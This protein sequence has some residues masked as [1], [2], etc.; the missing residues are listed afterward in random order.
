MDNHVLVLFLFAVALGAY[1]QTVSGFAM[2][3][4]VMGLV[5]GLHLLP[6][7]FTAVVISLVSL[8]NLSL[9]L[10]RQHQ[11]VRWTI[12]A[13]VCL[14]M[15][16]AT[17][18]GV[19]LLQRLSVNATQTLRLLL[20]GFILVGG[21]LLMLR[22]HQR[23]QPSPSACALL[24]GS[25]GGLFGGLFSASGPPLVFYL[26]RQPYAV[27]IARATLLAVFIV[28]TLSRIVYAG[29]SGG[30]THDM[31]R[32]SAAALPVVF[33]GNAMGRRYAPPLSEHNM[34]RLAFA[35]LILLGLSLVLT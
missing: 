30:I 15:I 19:W 33:V 24:M 9:A 16:P 22:P 29:V 27:A 7:A 26:Y 20:G 23:T 17:I 4:L 8:L 34:R 31:L 32:L 28:A 13:L 5:S 1:V 25:L 11:H 14:G 2:G 12:V 35:L 6:I 21:T 10:R 18:L 3:L